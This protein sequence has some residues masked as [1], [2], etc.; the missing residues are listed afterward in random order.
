[1]GGPDAALS[2]ALVIV[3]SAALRPGRSSTARPASRRSRAF[4]AV[5][6]LATVIVLVAGLIGD[7]GS[8]AARE[9]AATASVAW[10]GT[11]LGIT[12]SSTARW[13]RRSLAEGAGHRGCPRRRF[14]IA[15]VGFLIG[16]AQASSSSSP[17]ASGR[18]PSA[19]R[20]LAQPFEDAGAAGRRPLRPD[21]REVPPPHLGVAA[22]APDAERRRRGLHVRR[23]RS[24]PAGPERRAAGLRGEGSV[25]ADRVD[26]PPRPPGGSAGLSP[27]RPAGGRSPPAHH[28]PEPGG[29]QPPRPGRCSAMRF[30]ASGTGTSNHG[31]ITSR[32]CGTADGPDEANNCPEPG[33]PARA[34]GAPRRRSQAPAKTQEGGEIMT[35]EQG[36]SCSLARTRAGSRSK[37]FGAGLIAADRRLGRLRQVLGQAR[38]S[39]TSP[40]S[41]PMRSS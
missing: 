1:M 3:M 41:G 25:P 6:A 17:S 29:P 32:A 20:R 21:P 38:S 31:R 23:P 19:R 36:R 15:L 22:H 5:L 10:T 34:A 4:G 13:I 30:F 8:V 35:M 26:R 2:F 11:L 39:L 33:R 28:V 7:H 37:G 27:G 14:S 9:F 18:P 16:G 40:R 12:I 24:R